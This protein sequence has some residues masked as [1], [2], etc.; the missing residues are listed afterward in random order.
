MQP[1]IK[2]RLNDGGFELIRELEGKIS[3]CPIGLARIRQMLNSQ[4]EYGFSRLPA[5]TRYVAENSAKR[6]IKLL[7]EFP[8]MKRTI[9]VGFKDGHRAGFKTH[10][11]NVALP[12]GVFV[13]DV[14]RKGDEYTIQNS[15]LFAVATTISDTK[16]RLYRFPLSNL[17]HHDGRICWGDNRISGPYLNLAAVEGACV[18]YF[19]GYSNNHWFHRDCV[20]NKFEWGGISLDHIELFLKKLAEV[21]KF[22]TEWL[23]PIGHNV[24]DQIRS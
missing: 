5:G 13:F 20:S 19:N 1:K 4:E 21:E 23:E 10:V 2:L 22:P 16:D 6:V 7:M 17:G 3:V 8:P 9:N 18:T 24:A 15:K 11:D 14:A 12:G